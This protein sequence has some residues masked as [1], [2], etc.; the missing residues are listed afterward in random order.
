MRRNRRAQ[1]G[2]WPCATCASLPSFSRR[3]RGPDGHRHICD[4]RLRLPRRLRAVRPRLLPGSLISPSRESTMR[5]KLTFGLA[6]SSSRSQSRPVPTRGPSGRQ[7][8][9]CH[10]A[11]LGLPSA[12]AA[13]QRMI[14]EALASGGCVR[15]GLK[16][17]EATG[18]VQTRPGYPRQDLGEGEP[19]RR[20]QH[21]QTRGRGT[22]R[23]RGGRAAGQG[24]IRQE[25]EIRGRNEAPSAWRRRRGAFSA[26]CRT[27]RSADGP[28][29]SCST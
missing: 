6:G 19:K 4:R 3:S 5:T 22:E 24:A 10:P 26:S 23:Y 1:R 15:H 27:P 7:P 14:A 9:Q 28:T 25:A 13:D 21:R 29:M 12:L 2:A 17:L 20:E 8:V 11:R 16:V 18:R